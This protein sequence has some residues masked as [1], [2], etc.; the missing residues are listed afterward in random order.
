MSFGRNSS[1]AVGAVMLRADAVGHTNAT[2]QITAAAA[3]SD[4]MRVTLVHL[5]F[6]E[7]QNDVGSH[8]MSNEDAPR[9]D[10]ASV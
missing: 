5:L 10:V 2:K 3:G 9:F 7:L 8:H 6:F 1:P 4:M